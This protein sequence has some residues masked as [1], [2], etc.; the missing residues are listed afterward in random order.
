MSFCN[1]GECGWR[2][3]FGEFIA[4]AFHL[5]AEHVQRVLRRREQLLVVIR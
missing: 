1:F 4:K 3:R 2:E 5:L